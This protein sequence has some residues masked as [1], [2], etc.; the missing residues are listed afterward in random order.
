MSVYGIVSSFDGGFHLVLLG[1][2]AFSVDGFSFSFDLVLVVVGVSEHITEDFDGLGSIVF[3]NSHSVRGIFTRS[4]SVKLATH[5]FNIEFELVS[6][7]I[8]SSLRRLRKLQKGDEKYLEVEMFKEVSDTT[9]FNSFLSGTAFNEDRDARGRVI[10]SYSRFLRGE[11]AGPV[12]S[13]NFDTIVELRSFYSIIRRLRV[14]KR[15]YQQ[16]CRTSRIQGFHQQGDH[17]N[18]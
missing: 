2:D 16:V 9:V 14:W 15:T 1:F 13:G 11:L 7:S 18:Q 10:W 8:L 6:G 5:I 3:E 17:R 12:L 4:V